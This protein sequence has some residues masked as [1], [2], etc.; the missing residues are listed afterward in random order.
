MIHKAINYRRHQDNRLIK[1][2]LK[3]ANRWGFSVVN[4]PGRLR[5]F[6][7]ACS[8]GCCSASH[9][10]G[11]LKRQASFKEKEQIRVAEEKIYETIYNA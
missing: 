6:N 10:D 7:L 1:K 5:K 4:I 2:R 9:P 11:I 8:C 3:I